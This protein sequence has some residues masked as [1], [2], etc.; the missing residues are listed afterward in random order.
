MTAQTGFAVEVR[1]REILS[2][3]AVGIVTA[4]WIAVGA[5][6]FARGKGWELLGGG[7]P[8]LV[9]GITGLIFAASNWR[10]DILRWQD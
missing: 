9:G 5:V 7:L 8:G 4:M 1:R 3:L 2:V 10:R 6:T